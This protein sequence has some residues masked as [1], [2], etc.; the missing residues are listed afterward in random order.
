METQVS[1]DEVFPSAPDQ[2]VSDGFS[3]TNDH[4][5]EWAMHKIADLRAETARFQAHFDAQMGAIRKA[6]EEREAF[7]TAHLARYFDSVPRRETETQSKYRLPCGELVRRKQAPE[8]SRDDSLLVPFLMEN[9]MDGFVKVKPSTDWA[10][11]KKQCVLL[12]DG[13][14]ADSESG[15]VLPGVIAEQRPDK[16][17]VKIN[18]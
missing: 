16:F 3:I 12:E 8:F 10:A 6:N 11:L 9:G 4:T 5:A 14:V 17:E 13:T 15:M 7:F 2:G 1:Y 18:A